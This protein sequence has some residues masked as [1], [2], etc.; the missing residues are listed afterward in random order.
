[1]NDYEKYVTEVNNIFKVL[2]TLKNAWTNSDSLNLIE[3]VS[4]YKTLVIEAATLLQ[5]QIKKSQ[6][7]QEEIL[8]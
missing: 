3:E 2:E 4:E 8:E 5:K 6:S 1:M 7:S